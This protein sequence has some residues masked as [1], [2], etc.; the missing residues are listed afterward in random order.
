MAYNRDS[1]GG[2]LDYTLLPSYMQDNP[3][4]M[5]DKVLQE[6]VNDIRDS[7]GEQNSLNQYLIEQQQ[8][9]QMQ[10][11]EA[12]NEAI[13]NSQEAME[14][15][16]A[17]IISSLSSG[18][19]SLASAFESK[20]ALFENV[21]EEHSIKIKKTLDNISESLSNPTIT[22]ANE[23]RDMAIERMKKGLLDKA[24]EAFLKAY[25]LND[26]DFFVNFQIGKIY[27]YGNIEGNNLIDLDKSEKFLKDALRYINVEDQ[28]D[29]NISNLKAEILLENAQV[30]LVKANELYIK[31]NR[32][33]TD[34]VKQAYLNTLKYAKQCSDTAGNL[35]MS[36]IQ[37]SALIIQI[38]INIYIDNKQEA[39]NLISVLLE[40]DIKFIYLLRKDSDF[41]NIVD[42][43]NNA[44]FK[45]NPKNEEDYYI[46]MVELV[47]SN[48]IECAKEAI[49]QYIS[50][51]NNINDL[52]E[53]YKKIRHN[54]LVNNI[55][56]DID[57]TITKNKI[58]DFFFD[59]DNNRNTEFIFEQYNN[60]LE[61]NL[62]N[63]IIPEVNNLIMKDSENKNINI[64]I[65][66]YVLIINNKIEEA[67]VLLPDIIKNNST[68][69]YIVKNHKVFCALKQSLEQ[70][71]KKLYFE[72]LEFIK[73]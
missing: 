20:F 17:A 35:K 66:I 12:T 7:L 13:R 28:K 30:N 21:I 57:K 11:M 68:A 23:F 59:T 51:A 39:L 67:K 14:R 2:W 62:F 58:F 60:I 36:D 43:I 48:N 25:D 4:V 46:K 45:V 47:K 41:K 33:L 16:N 18:F 34:T 42:D 8:E 72:S 15:N 29:V 50:K 24:L 49:S 9:Q 55:M 53:K 73:P 70:E 64:I 52:I 10:M 26:T 56:E 6:T 5:R 37:N 1:E 19:T 22:K 61:S 32:Q 71:K 63:N 69:Y 65:R 38:R 31:E 40:N 54:D 3:K 27:L 44:F